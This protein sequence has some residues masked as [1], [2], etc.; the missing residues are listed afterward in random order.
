MHKG[1]QLTEVTH[2]LRGPLL[3]ILVRFLPR[4]QNLGAALPFL[5]QLL[6]SDIRFNIKL[7]CTAADLKP[8]NYMQVHVTL[9]CDKKIFTVKITSRIDNIDYYASRRVI[10]REILMRDI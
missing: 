6:W 2:G 3:T 5:S 4:E 9:W 8:R 1:L 10:Y 7:S